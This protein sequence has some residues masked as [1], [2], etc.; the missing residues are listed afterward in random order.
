MQIL[1]LSPK[2]EDF[3][4]QRRCLGAKL[5]SP[6][7]RNHIDKNKGTPRHPDYRPPG[8]GQ[9]EKCYLYP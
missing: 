7:P 1:F 9:T 8:Y 5:S 2:S 3:H 6:N 4:S